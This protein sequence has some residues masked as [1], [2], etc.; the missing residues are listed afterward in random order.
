MYK[1]LRKV[2][3]AAEKRGW[4]LG[5]GGKHHKLTHSSGRKISV[6]MSPSDKNAHLSLERE[7]KRVEREAEEP[8][9]A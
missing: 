6:S 3:K 2:V 1:E 9:A 8:E 5:P 7:I 4:V